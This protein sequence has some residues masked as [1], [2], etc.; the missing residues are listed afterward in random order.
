MVRSDAFVSVIFRTPFLRNGIG[1]LVFLPSR[2]QRSGVAG[3]F[4]DELHPRGEA[5][6][7]VDV[8]EVGL[9]GAR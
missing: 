2:R 6:F 8:G 7:G 3:C 4:L 9:H 1:G 5:E